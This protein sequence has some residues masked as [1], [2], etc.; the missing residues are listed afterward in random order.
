M[1]NK[2]Y[3]APLDPFSEYAM[4][5]ES[6]EYPKTDFSQFGFKGKIDTM[7]LSEAYS[8]ALEQIPMFSSHLLEERNGLFY[9]PYWEFD[10]EIPNRLNIADARHITGDTFEP[11]ELSTRFYAS[12]TR[13][14]IDL[15]REF[16]FN[17]SLIRATDDEY[18]FSILYH[19]SAMD[20]SKAYRVLTTMLTRYHEKVKG[21]KPAWAESL[22]MAALKRSGSLVKPLPLTTFAKEQLTDLWFTNPPSKVA[23]VATQEIRDFK[24]VKGRF[25]KRAVIDDPK[26]LK[27]LFA[28]VH[29]NEAT[30]N[31]LLFAV[32]R[33]TLT[34]WNQEHGVSAER[35]RYLLITSLQGRTELPEQAGAGLAGLIFVSAGHEGAD[36]DSLTRYFR[37]VR[38]DQLRR[39]VD[40]QFYNTTCYI[41]RTLRLLPQKLRR[42]IGAL[43][44]ESA[45]CTF[46]LSNLGVVWPKWVDGK[47][48]MDS[49][50]VKVGDFE[51]ND[52]HSS[53]SIGKNVGLGLTTRTHNRRLYLNFVGDRFRYHKEEFEELVDRFVA[54]L[55]SAV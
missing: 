51:I 52:V 48:T 13:R 43:I 30:L 50:I 15:T 19:H 45:P 6:D 36:L 55:I 44:G 40:I 35:F 46:Y 11:M 33:K 25:S 23:T 22:G 4:A 38:A 1:N 10:S 16:P 12:R 18:I 27:G 7:A 39:G 41:S 47:P 3:K 29:K 32:S 8:E 21:K 2:D 28:R 26:L 53:A 14:R 24:K 34:Q 20:P 5:M 42:K 31:D 37:D 17:C 54:E 9:Q 49:A